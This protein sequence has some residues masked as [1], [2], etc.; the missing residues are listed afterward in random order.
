M[1]ATV[2]LFG[3]EGDFYADA[4]TGKIIT[5]ADD[6]PANYLRYVGATA[7]IQEHV[8]FWQRQYIGS[9]YT[10]DG[11]DILDMAFTLADG[12]AEPAESEYRRECIRFYRDENPGLFGEWNA[13]AL[14][15]LKAKYC[16]DAEEADDETLQRDFA[17][18]DSP[19]E[20]I[21][22]TAGKYGLTALADWTPAKAETFMRR[23]A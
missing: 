11:I 6:M 3:G 15:S 1:A 12:S 20:S 7:D 23:F 16:L 10:P 21:D 4:T 14:G 8:T 17:D 19:A 22:R 13:A 2:K 9:A 5:T 18:G